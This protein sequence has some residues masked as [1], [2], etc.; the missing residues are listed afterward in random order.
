MDTVY[1]V[2]DTVYIE[3]KVKEIYIDEKGIYYMCI[4][5]SA[6]GETCK[7]TVGPEVLKC[8]L[9]AVKV[10]RPNLNPTTMY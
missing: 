4:F 6:Y 8:N 1:N 5:K 7:P 3:A 2:G 9:P 10:V